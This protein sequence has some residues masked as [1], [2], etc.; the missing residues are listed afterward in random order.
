VVRLGA[1]G[2]RI[3]DVAVMRH[4]R[5]V[6]T[7]PQGTEDGWFLAIIRSTLVHSILTAFFPSLT[8]NC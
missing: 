4:L 3:E 1:V 6:G 5:L 2:W 8:H 7:I